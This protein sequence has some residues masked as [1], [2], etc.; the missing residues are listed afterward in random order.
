MGQEENPPEDGEKGEEGEQVRNK[1]LP[2]AKRK[3][4]LKTKMFFCR[5]IHK[6]I[7]YYLEKSCW[8]AFHHRPYGPKGLYVVAMSDQEYHQFKNRQ[9]KP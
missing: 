6:V 2:K 7:V 4:L 9:D 3:M 1:A 5:Q 8:G